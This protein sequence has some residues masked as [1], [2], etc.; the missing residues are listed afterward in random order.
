MAKK[1]ERLQV[2]A[3]PKGYQLPEYSIE[4][5]ISEGGFSIVY[6]ATHMPTRKRV[7]IKE[8]FP[9]K[10][11]QRISKRPRVPTGWG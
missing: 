10:Y 1:S 8:F 5:P 2:N 6:L 4:K 7:V 9:I 3:L 11:A